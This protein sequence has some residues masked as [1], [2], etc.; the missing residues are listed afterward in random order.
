MKLLGVTS[1]TTLAKYKDDPDNSI[2]YAHLSRKA[3]LFY[4]PSI[5]E[6]LDSKVQKF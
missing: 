5:L 1:K 6:F 4:R 3:V 2:R